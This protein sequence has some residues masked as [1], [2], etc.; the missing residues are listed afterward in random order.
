MSEA[1]GSPPRAWGSLSWPPRVRAAGRF[2]PTRVGITP[3]LFLWHDPCS[4]S[5]PRAWGSLYGL[6]LSLD[7]LRFTPTRVGITRWSARH[8]PGRAVH[9]HARGD[10]GPWV[11]SASRRAGSPPRAWGSHEQE[12]RLNWRLRFT[13]TRVGITLCAAPASGR[14]AVHPHARGDHAAALR[15]AFPLDGSPPRAWGS[16]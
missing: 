11:G 13:P 5:P 7:L 9:P 2:T 1:R 14:A 3:S 8:P 16:R 12:V 6:T 15:S 4:G 10:H